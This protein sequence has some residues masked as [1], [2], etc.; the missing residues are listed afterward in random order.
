MVKEASRKIAQAQWAALEAVS[1]ELVAAGAKV[2]EITRLTEARSPTVTRDVLTLA[3]VPIYEVTTTL[4]GGSAD[5]A[6]RWLEA[7]A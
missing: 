5:V 2:E 3:G 4:R 1:R 6:G 7:K